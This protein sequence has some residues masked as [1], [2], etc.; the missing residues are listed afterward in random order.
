MVTESAQ[1]EKRR[2]ARRCELKAGVVSFG[3]AG[4]TCTVR[5]ISSTGASLEVASP[6]GIS[7]TFTLLIAMEHAKR[8]CRVVRRKEKRIGVTFE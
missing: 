8:A 5:N 2:A 3:G 6:L 4:I 7:E 1:G